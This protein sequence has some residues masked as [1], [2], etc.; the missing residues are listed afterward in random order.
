MQAYHQYQQ[1][2]YMQ[3]HMMAAQQHPMAYMQQGGVPYVV[4]PMPPA[5]PAGYVPAAHQAL[6]W[7]QQEMQQ[8][9]QQQHMYHAP[10]HQHHQQQPAPLTWQQQQA[11]QQQRALQQR[12]QNQQQPPPPPQQQQAQQPSRSASAASGSSSMNISPTSAPSNDAP[13]AGRGNA[14]QGRAHET[15]PGRMESL[16]SGAQRMSIT[17]GDGAA[18]AC[19]VCTFQ[20]AGAKADF[21]TCEVCGS[22]R[23]Q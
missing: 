3:Q 14:R 19:T 22:E 16:T 5:Y 9:H 1:A 23:P 6:T 11:L 17:G 12:Q 2:M 7:Q 15:A 20:H 21:L 18:W 13:A 4:A 10:Q 8:Q